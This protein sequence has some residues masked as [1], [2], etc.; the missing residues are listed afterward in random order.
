MRRFLKPIANTVYYK[1]P[2]STG[3]SLLQRLTLLMILTFSLTLAAQAESLTFSFADPVG[4]H[5]GAIDVTAM[6]FNFDNATGDYTITLTATTANPFVGQFRVNINLYNPDAVISDNF[7][8]DVFNDYNLASA[9]TSLTLTG[10][11]S[12]LLAWHSGDRI[13]TNDLVFGYPT[14]TGTTLFRSSV[15][16]FPMGFL[17]NEDPI[18]YGAGGFTTVTTPVLTVAIDIKPNNFPNSINPGNQGVIPVAILTDGVFDAATVD[19]TTIRFGVNG[20][21]TAPAHYALEDVDGDGQL[22]MIL[23][24]KTQATGLVC[25]TTSAVLTASTFGGQAIRGTDSVNTVGC[26]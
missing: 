9:T 4:D 1:Q 26:K 16:N 13:A 5:T 12:H 2:L 14:G 7:F 19:P 3:H 20:N 11:N 23:H 10:T 6:S 21:E 8:S 18:A 24:F 15:S 22:D 25:G 17:T